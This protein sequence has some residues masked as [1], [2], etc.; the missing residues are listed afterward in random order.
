M[1]FDE[2]THSIA[3]FNGQTLTLTES[4]TN[5]GNGQWQIDLDLSTTAADM[6]S[7][8]IGDPTSDFVGMSIGPGGDPLQLTQPFALSS[9]LMTV[10]GSTIHFPIFFDF[11]GD[12]SASSN[13]WDGYFLSPT[14]YG[15]FFGI[16]GIGV[17]NV[18]LKFTGTVVVTP[19]PKAVWDGLGMLGVVGVIGMMRRRGV[20]V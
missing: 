2:G 20:R 3:G 5:L 18:D 15:G 16:E 17:Q 7:T 14:S 4:Q 10:T 9:A 19:L 13:P 1:T 6:F 12:L 11:I 8:G